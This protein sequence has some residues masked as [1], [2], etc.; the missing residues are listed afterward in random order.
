MQCS[1]DIIFIY[2]MTSSESCV[3]SRVIVSNNNRGYTKGMNK[4]NSGLL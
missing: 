2:I 4:D 3:D 1:M